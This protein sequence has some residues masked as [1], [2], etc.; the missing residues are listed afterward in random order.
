MQL[1][2][3]EKLDWHRDKDGKG[4]QI[5]DILT[6][7]ENERLSFHQQRIEPGGSIA[8]ETYPQ[9][10][11]HFCV[12]GEGVVKAGGKENAIRP[13]V[14]ILVAP[15][16]DYEVVNTGDDDLHLLTIVTPPCL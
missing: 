4:C 16:E 3:V 8:A 6:S 15:N 9:Q 5:K 1:I 11:A 7:Q 14:V 12:G 10:R 2:D 13:G